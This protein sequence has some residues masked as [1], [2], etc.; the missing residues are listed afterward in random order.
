MMRRAACPSA[1]ASETARPRG[2]PTVADPPGARSGRPLPQLTA[3]N[4]PFWTGGAHGELRIRRWLPLFRPAEDGGIVALPADLLDAA[5]HWR[6]IRPMVTSSRFEDK[7]AITGIG[8]SRVG[9]RLLVPHS[10]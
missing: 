1:V 4:E 3:L 10:R 5:A 8:S 2:G 9:R 7:A 6:A